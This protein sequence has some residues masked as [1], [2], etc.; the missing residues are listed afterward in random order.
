MIKTKLP[1]IILRNMVLLP[2]G[3]LKLEIENEEDKN[4]IYNAVNKHNGYCLL[5]TPK[6]I[7]N[8]NLNTNE[9]P[10]IGIIGKI[11]S[12]IVLPNEHIRINIRGI[13]RAHIFEYIQKEDILDAIIGPVKIDEIK[14]EENDASLRV[15]KREF[16]NYVNVMPNISN[17]IVSKINEEQSLEKITDIIVNI[18]PLNFQNK[19]LFLMTTNPIIRGNYLIDLLVKE[20]KVERLEKNI[21]EDLQ[22]E[23]DKTQKEFILREKLNVIK[24]ELGEKD[25]KEEDIDLIRKKISKLEAPSNIIDRLTK[26]VNRFETIPFTSP[27][28]TITKNYIDTLMSIPFGVYTKDEES[29]DKIKKVLD[30]NHNGLENIKERI[31]EYISVKK[32]TNSLTS[33]II[34]LVGP[35]GTGKTS[36]AYSIAK[37]LNRNF[38]KISVGGVSDENEIIGHRK[39]YVGAMPGRIISSIIKAK[40]MNPLFLI[41]EIDKM[42]KGI[43]GDPAAA[44]LEVLDKEQNKTFSDNYIEEGIDLSNV[45][46][47]LTANNIEEIPYALQDRLEIIE[48]SS[49]TEFE[50]IDIVKNHLFSILLEEHGLTNDITISDSAIKYLISNYTKEAGVRELRRVLSTILRKIAK[51]QV[52]NKKKVNITSKEI[53]KYLGKEKFTEVNNDEHDPGVVN[54]LGYTPFGGVLLPI[55]TSFYDGTGKIILTGSLGDVMKESANVALGYVKC[56]YKEFKI[57]KTLLE[58]NDLHINALEGATK[59]DGPSAGVTLTTAIISSLTGIKVSH[60]IAMTGEITLKGKVLK[61]GG[62]KEKVIGAYNQGVN[63]IF[64]PKTNENDLEEIPNEIKK[65]VKFILVDN[66]KEIYDNIFKGE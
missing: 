4:I 60:K 7:T 13:N 33:P 64:I 22:K 46:F 49:Y 12:N 44:M 25:S 36:L 27:E 19:Y 38:V 51:E 40:S 14:E 24:K 32:L 2:L 11:T 66:Y 45:M 15:I 3:E 6:Y 35:P 30:D 59:K 57:N 63:T 29:L 26:E 54:G 31:L 41:D 17:M 8:E 58:K 52:N 10:N 21:D 34:C 5:V 65:K 23:L 16:A 20:E 48:L 62:L 53:K 37:A 50:K 39:T 61:I 1:V 55:E 42:G 43:Q 56:N 9:L 47:V 18:L 28:Y